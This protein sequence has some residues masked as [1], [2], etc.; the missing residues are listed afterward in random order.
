MAGGRLTARGITTMILGLTR[1]FND[2]MQ[3]STFSAA[4]L[5]H[6]K[7]YVEFL[8]ILKTDHLFEYIV[9]RSTDSSRVRKKNIF[10]NKI[11]F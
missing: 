5:S 11:C 6:G 10:I 9:I 8:L 3:C 1:G 4:H 2:S 7:S